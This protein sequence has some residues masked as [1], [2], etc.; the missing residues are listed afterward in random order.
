MKVLI[1]TM[2]VALLLDNSTCEHTMCLCL[3][4]SWIYVDALLSF[5]KSRC[6]Q[7]L[8]AWLVLEDILCRLIMP[9]M[10]LEEF[11]RMSCVRSTSL[12]G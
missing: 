1:R 9:A 11:L 5:V 4:R 10:Y 2:I 3:R 6:Y 12:P 7:V 8:Y